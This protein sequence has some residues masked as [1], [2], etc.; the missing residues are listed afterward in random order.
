MALVDC[1]A[2]D[3][4]GRSWHYRSYRRLPQEGHRYALSTQT[5]KRRIVVQSKFPWTLSKRVAERISSFSG[6]PHIYEDFY[7]PNALEQDFQDITPK[8]EELVAEATNFKQ[9][10]TPARSKVVSR[11]EWVDSNINIFSQLMKPLEEKLGDKLGNASRKI[12]AVQMGVILSWMSKRVLGQ[13]DLLVPDKPPELQGQEGQQTPNGTSNQSEQSGDWVYYVGQNIALLEWRY[14][15]TPKDFRFWIALHELTHRAQFTGVK[16]LK[17]HF[18]D[19]AKES[20][21]NL[22]SD[23]SHLS[24]SIKQRRRQNGSEENENDFN[25]PYLLGSEK[26]KEILDKLS[27]M[28]SL[29]EGHGEVMMDRAAEGYVPGVDRF[30]KVM[31]ERRSQSRGFSGLLQKILGIETKLRQYEAGEKFVLSVEKTGGND[32]LN[33][34]WE[35]PEHL[36]T[37]QEIKNPNSWIERI[38][39]G[40]PASLKS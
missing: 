38:R 14:G 36:P 37:M 30:H 40:K 8:A 32:L 10:S 31:R 39:N 22:D 6:K 35:S 29:L 18:L 27:G 9:S 28:M 1:P 21:S 4:G 20:L 19:L 5:Q 33:V 23:L 25:L 26:Q 15:F 24:E 2:I 16:W 11:S 13:Y 3:G 17:Q 12:G 34:A 7:D